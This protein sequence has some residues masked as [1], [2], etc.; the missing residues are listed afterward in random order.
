MQTRTKEQLKEDLDYYQ[1]VYK[2][3]KARGFRRTM[4]GAQENIDRTYDRIKN[5]KDK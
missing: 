4:D 1:G 5:L 3:A 2:Q